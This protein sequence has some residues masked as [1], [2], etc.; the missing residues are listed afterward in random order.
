MRRWLKRFRRSELVKENDESRMLFPR[1][2]TSP[3][4]A[5][6]N[7]NVDLKGHLVVVGEMLCSAPPRPLAEI[8]SGSVVR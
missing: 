7:V 3:V 2:E 6:R 4:R 8:T 5:E 1:L